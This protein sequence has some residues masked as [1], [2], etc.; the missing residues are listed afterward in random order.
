MKLLFFE[1]YLNYVDVVIAQTKTMK[2][3]LTHLYKLKKI[4]IIPN[5]VSL[6]N[7]NLLKKI[8]FNLPS[9]IK[10]LFL[11]HYYPHKNLEILIPLSVEIKKRGLKFKIITTVD[12]SQ[13]SGAGK[14]INDIDKYNLENVVYNIG[15]VDMNHVPYLYQQCDALLMPTLLESYGLP[16]IEAMQNRKSIFTSDYDFARDVCKSAAFAASHG[17]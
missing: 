5:A 4:V 8:I 6:E 14:F 1:Q 2:M 10:L 9:G 13:H 16:Y 15:K 7:V 11:T 17:E 3:R 12:A